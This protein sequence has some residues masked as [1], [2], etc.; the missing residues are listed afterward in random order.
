MMV[1]IMMM[2]TVDIYYVPG[3]LLNGLHVSSHISLIATLQKLAVSEGNAH[4]VL[5]LQS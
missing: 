4:F 2:M 1:M 3:T 5:E